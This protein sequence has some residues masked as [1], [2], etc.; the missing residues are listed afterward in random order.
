MLKVIIEKA[1]EDRTLLESAET[2]AAIRETVQQLN[3]GKLRVAEPGENGWTVN[4][5]VKKAVI[6]F[7]PIS[8]NGNHHYGPF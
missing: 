3:D 6:L 5:W 2:L 8:K 1:W 4:E 7:F